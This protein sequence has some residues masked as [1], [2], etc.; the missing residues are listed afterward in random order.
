MQEDNPSEQLTLTGGESSRIQTNGNPDAALLAK[1]ANQP[2]EE[3]RV[4]LLWQRLAHMGI[5]DAI[6][7]IGTHMLSIALV[8]LVVWIMRQLSRQIPVAEIPQQAAFAA[9][10]PTVTPTTPLPDLPPFEA[11][12]ETRQNSVSRLALFHTTIPSRP[13]TEVITY[14]VQK[15]DTVFGIAEKFGLKPETILWGNYFVLADNPHALNEGQV[16]NILPMNGTY[17]RWSEG[18]GLNGVAA[19][20]SVK[21][22]DILKWPGNH[23]DPQTI[24]DWAHPNIK[25]GTFLVIPGGKREF[26]T[27]SAPRITRDNPAVASILGPGS[28]GTIVEGATGGGTFIWPSDTHDLSGYDYTPSTNHFGIDIRGYLGQPMWASDGGVV[29]Y[30]GWNNYGY[31]N[32]I[33]IDHGNGWQTLYAHVEVIYVLCGQSVFQGTP[34][35]TVGSTGK[36]SGPHIHFEMRHDTYGRVNPWNF[37]P[38]P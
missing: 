35:G 36:S 2:E 23:L 1:A 12:G 22:E 18:E 8:L 38:A 33:V 37:L 27:W 20:Y 29:V 31:G 10:I 32:V 6:L 4:S 5:A 7:R 19:G 34:L 15:G 14:T 16:L 26:I 24:G 25:A 30:A 13:R 17:H 3:S 9:A 11:L 21:P 28:C